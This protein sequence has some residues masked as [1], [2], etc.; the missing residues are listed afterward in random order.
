MDLL[1]SL[2]VH[3]VR[4]LAAAEAEAKAERAR[5]SPASQRQAA[6]RHKTHCRLK[7]ISGSAAGVRILSPQGDQTRPM[8][9][10][11]RGA[12]FSMI[13]SLHGSPG[14]LPENT[15]WLD[16]FAGTGAV[17]IEA[18]SRGAGE[19]H[20]V[21]MSP[22][23]INNCLHPNLERC[24]VDGAAVVHTGRVE[25]FLRRASGTPRFAG[26]AFDFV[27]CC[28]PYEAVS[29]PEVLELLSE[30]PLLHENTILL[31]EYPK[32]VTGEIP[33]MVG[34]LVKLRDRRY[35]RTLVAVYGP[36]SVLD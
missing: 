10:V 36:E 16:L 26:G 13:S 7:I 23:V 25:D 14:G 29:Y 12:V 21:E 8:M 18:L 15:R 20:F 5:L 9:E 22:W 28:P 6:A 2:P 4:R 35:G 32:K 27:S 17:G 3:M 33:L 24:G 30:S 1:A 11:V 19:A 34:S 31:V